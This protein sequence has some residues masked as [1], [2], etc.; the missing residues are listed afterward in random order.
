VQ[1]EALQRLGRRAPAT[2]AFERVL[3]IAA[4]TEIEI[5]FV[6]RARAGLAR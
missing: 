6:A 5:D 2:A 1:A 3:A 4:H